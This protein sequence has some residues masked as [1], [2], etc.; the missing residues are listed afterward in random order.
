MAWQRPPLRTLGVAAPRGGGVR[1]TVGVDVVA[2]ELGVAISE[3]CGRP[4]WQQARGGRA[5][6]AL[7]QQGVGDVVD[8]VVVAVQQLSEVGIGV[9][10]PVGVDVRPVL[11]LLRLGVE[12]AD[13][14]AVGVG[15]A[16]HW[17][18]A[19]RGRLWRFPVVWLTSWLKVDARLD[20]DAA[21]LGEERL[22]LRSLSSLSKLGDVLFLGASV[23]CLGVVLVFGSSASSL[24]AGGVVDEASCVDAEE[25]P[26][27]LDVVVQRGEVDEL[28][29]AIVAQAAAQGTG[30]KQRRFGGRGKSP[31]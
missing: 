11:M 20:G 29:G 19:W 13:R 31:I 2:K 17:C 9:G 5:C 14:L 28:V 27:R 4:P 21:R 8:V 25:G 15:L 7:P 18:S 22:L 1:F 10:V 12:E 6:G 26:A 3:A 23:S 30:Q 24:V 16:P